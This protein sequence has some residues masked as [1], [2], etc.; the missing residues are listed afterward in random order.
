MRKFTQEELDE[1]IADYKNGMR[2]YEIAKKYDRSSSSVINKLK[3]LG[4]YVDSR[5]NTKRDVWDRVIELYKS[6]DKQAIM[7]KYPQLQWTTV[8]KKMS[9][10]GVELGGRKWTDEEMQF[11]KENYFKLSPKE[12]SLHFD[13]RRTPDAV[14]TK[15]LKAFGYSRDD[16]WTYDELN[17][18]RDNYSTMPIDDLMKLLP[19]K[20]KNAIILHGNQM[21][22]KSYFYHITYW[23]DKD[24][25]F[26]QDNW[27]KYSDTDLAV[28]LGKERN[29]VVWRRQRLGL[30]RLSKD[31]STYYDLN[32]YLRGQDWQWKKNTI[33]SCNDACIFTGSK[34]Y[35]IHHRYCVNQI[36]KDIF[37]KYDVIKKP[38][39]D[40][41]KD[42]LDTI[43]EYYYHESSLHPLGVCI[44]GDIHALYH[45]IYGKS[46]DSEAQWDRF[47]SDMVSGKYSD[48]I[49]F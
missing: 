10:L 26:L 33:A 37:D 44:R 20:T 39:S 38:F 40:Y 7:T 35:E 31:G 43:T 4:I 9:K 16:D 22:L 5:V 48:I 17:I 32:K 1:I 3:S 41:T 23:S 12:I 36:I 13:G 21:G 46:G 28:I 6:G 18:V 14:S 42:E 30:L 34:K 27:E 25:Q 11:L 19:G 24:T 29:S 15:A 49:M 8:I 45:S 47:Y 2:P